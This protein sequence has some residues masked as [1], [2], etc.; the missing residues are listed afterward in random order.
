M[1]YSFGGS[2]F[3]KYV[4]WTFKA[5]SDL[6][7]SGSLLTFKLWRVE[8]FTLKVP[9]DSEIILLLLSER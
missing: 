8:E 2:D 1:I 4:T 5:E 9:V 6:N 3:I 7:F